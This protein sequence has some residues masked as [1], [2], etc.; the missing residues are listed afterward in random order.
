LDSSD[1]IEKKAW[2]WYVALHAATG[3][4]LGFLLGWYAWFHV[5]RSDFLNSWVGFGLV[6][7]GITLLCAVLAARLRERFWDDWSSP[8]R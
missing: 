6:V 8:F 1:D 2:P 3:A 7:G 4:L 5:A